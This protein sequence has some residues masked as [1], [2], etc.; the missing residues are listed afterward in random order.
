LKR[1]YEQDEKNMFLWRYL[2]KPE[3]FV[4]NQRMKINEKARKNWNPEFY[5]NKEIL[6]EILDKEI[7]EI[8]RNQP[9]W[10]HAKDM[11]G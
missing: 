9:A 11:R 10:Q 8:E 6:G 7:K 5:Q 1:Y 2:W 3:S 4:Q